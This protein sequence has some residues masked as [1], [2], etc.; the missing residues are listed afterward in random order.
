M[1]SPETP[2]SGTAPLQDDAARKRT[3][4]SLLVLVAFFGA[5][6]YDYWPDLLQVAASAVNRTRE[7]GATPVQSRHLEARNLSTASPG[8]V[9]AALAVLEQQ[10]R[11]ITDY[12]EVTPEEPLPVL[13]VD[14]SL[15]AFDDGS[16][17][18]INVN[19]GVVDTDVA[20]IFMV[21]MVDQIKVNLA[22]Q[23]IPAGGYALYVVEASGL[24]NRLTG[25]PVDNWVALIRSR[26]VYIPLEEAWAMKVPSDDNG[27]YALL[28]A[29]LESGSFMRWF[30][31][32]YSLDSARLVANGETVEKVTGKT[33]A[34]NETAWL[35]S[36][37]RR[38]LHPRPCAAVIPSTSMFSFMCPKLDSGLK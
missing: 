8:Q 19:R 9:N 22:G 25:Q 35:A 13:F 18:V 14:G 21:L 30:A 23:F 5:L 38:K 10:Y 11:V 7:I 2:D 12:L 16:Q 3:I 20:P 37:D 31:T 26:Q 4:I 33:L 6:L 27:A 29:M 28:R 1:I 24:G 36:L 15:P 17:L 32:T 34:E